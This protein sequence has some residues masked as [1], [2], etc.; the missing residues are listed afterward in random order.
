MMLGSED[1]EQTPDSHNE[2]E[3]EVSA[4]WTYRA[5]P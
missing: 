4:L 1:E 3:D 5:F 2:D